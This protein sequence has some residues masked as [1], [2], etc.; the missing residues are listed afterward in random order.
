MKI[1]Y[2]FFHPFS[3]RQPEE[4]L[5]RSKA[6]WL[7]PNK[8]KI[9][10]LRFNDSN[11]ELHQFTKYDKSTR[12]N[13]FQFRYPKAADNRSNINPLVEVRIV[14]VH[15]N[16]AELILEPPPEFIRYLSFKIKLQDF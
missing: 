16:K 9:L 2:F 13:E 6:H 1:S 3:F 11:V 5:F 8:K 7:S 4:I 14:D 12:D 10:Y 15:N